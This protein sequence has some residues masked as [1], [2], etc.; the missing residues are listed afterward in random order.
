M[1]KR[2][3]NTVI[4]IIFLCV[5][6]VPGVIFAAPSAEELRVQINERSKTIQSLEK[7]IQGYRTQLNTTGKQITTLSGAVKELTTTSK[8][9]Q[10]DIKL[11]ET[12]IE[13]SELKIEE[14]SHDIGSKEEALQRSRNALATIVRNNQEYQN[15]SLLESYIANKTMGELWSDIDALLAISEGVQTHM[16]EVRMIKSELESTKV[17]KQEEKKSLELY[18]E[19]LDAQHK[20]AEYNRKTTS[21]L[22]SQTKNQESNYKKLLVDREAR[23]RA[24]E[25]ELA[26]LESQLKIVLDVSKLPDKGTGT[27]GWP[28]NSRRITQAFGDTEFSRQNPG[29]YNGRGHNGI[30][31]A[32][33]VGDPIFAAEGGKV[34]GVGDTD[35]SCPG[36]SYGR[37]VL[38]EHANGL[39]TLYAHLSVIRVGANQP[40][41]RGDT[42]GNA[43]NTGYSTGPHL[44]FTVYASQGVRIQSLPSKGCLGRVYTIPVAA[45]ASY[46][47]PLMYL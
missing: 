23:K 37:W 5:G 38:I 14:L 12:K 4:K 39:S 26:N 34:L 9:I 42:I 7:E 28:T 18:H 11:T 36:A 24:F 2:S 17:K 19:D 30:D 20:V 43:G 35:L 15:E 41:A 3:G 32:A 45:Y 1:H 21:D 6:I 25:T 22:L 33:S 44:H 31:I 46:L 29:V 40:V 13:T 27:L 47:N 8:K 10:T 16:A